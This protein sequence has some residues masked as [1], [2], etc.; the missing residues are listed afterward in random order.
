VGL[1]VLAVASVITLA[2]RVHA[3]RKATAGGG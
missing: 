3:V 1:W 2:Q